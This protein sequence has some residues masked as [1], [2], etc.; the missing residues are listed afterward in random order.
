[1]VLA[2]RASVR[3]VLG[4]GNIADW[5]LHSSPVGNCDAGYR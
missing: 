1:V 4:F 3:G 5:Y 2:F